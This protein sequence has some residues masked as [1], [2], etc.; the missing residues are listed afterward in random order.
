MCVKTD[1]IVSVQHVIELRNG[2]IL[3]LESRTED[4]FRL[5]EGAN[6]FSPNL[7]TPEPSPGI[8]PNTNDNIFNFD[9]IIEEILE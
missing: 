9:D 7:L 8:L 4:G 2:T 3:K 5:L 6:L 1:D